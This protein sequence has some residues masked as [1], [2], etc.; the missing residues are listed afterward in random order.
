MKGNILLS[1]DI[2]EF[3]MPREYG[4]P[5]PFEQQ[6]DVSHGGTTKILDLLAKYKIKATFYTTANFATHAKDIV[7]RIINEGHELASHGYVHD[8]FEVS[9]LKMS[10]DVLE[11]I[12]NVK[13]K[14]YRMARMMPVPEEEVYK[15]GYTYNSSINPTFLP[16]R[17]NKF[18]ESRTYFMREGVLQLP[19]SV[20]PFFRFPLFWISFH[21]LP[22]W[23]YFNFANWTIGRDGYLNT[24]FHPW[25]FMDI[26][27]KSK[28]NFPFYITRHTGEDMVRRFGL[29]IEWGL[30][31]GFHFTTTS[32]FIDESGLG[33]K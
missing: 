1:F 26:G 22:L 14:G 29:F 21:N 31:K 27:P 17:Y 12:A 28:Y 6:I 5:I 11:E 7:L 30:S 32:C 2:E 16:G 3:E 8:H 20:T 15:A 13:V 24:Y 9:H 10:K 4:D 33:G 25:E 18:N 23:Q 19:A